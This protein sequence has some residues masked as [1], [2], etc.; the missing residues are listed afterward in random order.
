MPKDQRISWNLKSEL[1][2]IESGGYGAPDKQ[3]TGAV[4]TMFQ[5]LSPVSTMDTPIEFTPAVSVL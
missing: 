2:F 4:A 5:T 3:V 1:E